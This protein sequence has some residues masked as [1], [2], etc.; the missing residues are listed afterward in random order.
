MADR[1]LTTNEL[2]NELEKYSFK[3]LHLHHTWKPT[4]AQFKGNNHLQMQQGMRNFHVNSRGFQDIAQHLTLF[5]DGKWVTGRPFYKA[6]ASIKGWNTGALAVEMI[7]NFD[8]PGTGA[9]NDLGYDVLEGEQKTSVLQLIK[10][11]GNKY[12]YQN[13]K[14]HREGPGVGKTCPGTSINKQQLINEAEGNIEPEKIVVG[15]NTMVL[16]RGNRGS[17]VRHLQMNLKGLAFNCGIPDGIYGK[18]TED[19]VRRFQ[20]IHNL[21]VDGIAGS[22]TLE[23]I[24]SIVSEIQKRLKDLGYDIGNIDGIYGDRTRNSVTTFQKKHGLVADGIA[25]NSTLNKLNS[26]S[27]EPQSSKNNANTNFER[28]VAELEN[29]LREINRLSNI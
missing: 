11:F 4:H 6:P 21:S 5:P 13:I 29:R 12:G 22:Q 2:I 27:G 15:G 28:R 17:A 20:T 10:W 26:V 3:Q 18:A 25:G 14:F 24:Y 7:G 8:I 19:A 9:Y 16:R 23:K 1:I